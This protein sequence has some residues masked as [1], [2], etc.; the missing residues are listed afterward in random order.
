MHS[1]WDN[2]EFRDAVM[3]TGKKQVIVA[4][5]VTDVCTTFLSL[6]LRAEGYTVFANVEGSGT[7]S[8]FIRDTSNARMQQ[9]GVHLVSLFAIVG[10]LMRDW[11]SPGVA[12]VVPYLTRWLPIYGMLAQG[13]AAA[14]GNG[15]AP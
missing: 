1:A 9:A 15:T 13:H 14:L 4:G 8:T 10:D 12:E 11:R 7:T 5:I 6:S 3:K 2:A